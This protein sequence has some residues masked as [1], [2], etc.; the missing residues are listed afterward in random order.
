M[1]N[2]KKE[3]M[4]SS[5][6]IFIKKLKKINKNLAIF[7]GRLHFFQKEMDVLDIVLLSNGY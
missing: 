3:Q 1:Y 2:K 5:I 4:K 6:F 7:N